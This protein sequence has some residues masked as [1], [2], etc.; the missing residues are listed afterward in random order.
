MPNSRPI[1]V[2]IQMFDYGL[3]IFGRSIVCYRMGDEFF[4]YGVTSSGDPKVL[5]SL[6]MAREFAA[7]ALP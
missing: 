4:L 7:S 6:G 2:P 3:G 1:T 5:P